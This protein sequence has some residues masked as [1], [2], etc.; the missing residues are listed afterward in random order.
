MPVARAT[1]DP[2]SDGGSA[3]PER[4]DS[5]LRTPGRRAFDLDRR[6]TG[7]GVDRHKDRGLDLTAEEVVARRQ[8][9]RVMVGLLVVSCAIL[10]P[11]LIAMAVYAS[12]EP[13]GPK[14]TAPPGFKPVSDSYFAYVVPKTWANNGEFSDAAGDVDTSGPTGWAGEHYAYFTSTPTLSTTPPES[15]E[16]FNVA[17]PSPFTLFDGHA[18]TVP[19]ASGAFEYA[20]TRPGGFHAVVID[21]WS[22][23]TGVEM[24]LMVDAPPAVTDELVG[25]LRAGESKS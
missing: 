19:G 9:R 7:S 3:L 2:V 5:G 12:N 1:M 13:N 14:V 24:W 10:V 11:A 25:S 23:A 16:A 21:S 15:L 18:I 17:R 22:D 8:N 6:P 20:A 4:L